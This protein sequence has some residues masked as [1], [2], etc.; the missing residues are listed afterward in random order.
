MS[1]DSIALIGFMATG[2]ST[3]GKALKNRLGESYLFVETD[4]IVIEIAGKSIPKI[5]A[6]DGESKFRE[7]EIEAC[8]TVAQLSKVIIS[9]GGGVVLNQEN[10]KVL[11]QFCYLV[12]LT[13]TPDVIYNRAMSEGKYNRPVIDKKDPFNE[14]EK[15]LQSREPYY[16]SA[17]EIVIDTSEKPIEAIVDE[18]LQKTNLS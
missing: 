17:A 10:V 9:C 7:Y 11:R 3:I 5:F 13:A 6:E 18:I 1:K 4:L 8:K 16:T 15:V 12:L 14:I 2:K